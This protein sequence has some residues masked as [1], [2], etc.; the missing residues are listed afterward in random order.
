MRHPLRFQPLPLPRLDL[1]RSDEESTP[2]LPGTPRLPVIALPLPPPRPSPTMGSQLLNEAPR[3]HKLATSS[4]HTEV[5]LPIRNDE[6]EDSP[7]ETMLQNLTRYITKDEDYP[8]ARGGF[9]E[10]WKCTYHMDLQ[11][12][13][14]AVKSLQVYAA[15]QLGPAKKKKIQV[16]DS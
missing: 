5:V 2:N 1:R 4:S 14:V 12:I 9:G 7:P 11:P 8:V 16:S 3:P 15:D 10:I 6:R 13:K